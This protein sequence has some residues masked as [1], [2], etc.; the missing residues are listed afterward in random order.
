MGANWRAFYAPGG[1]SDEA[2]DYWVG[3][4]QQVADSELWSQ[5]RADNGLAPFALFGAEFEAFVN[6][7]VA[8]I[9]T[10]SQDLGLIQ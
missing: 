3:A 5:L 4:V 1:I 7:Q 9:R 2:Y 6:E 10:I 8:A